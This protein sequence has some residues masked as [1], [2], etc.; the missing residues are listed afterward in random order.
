MCVRVGC[1]RMCE[2]KYTYIQG[3]RGKSIRMH[4]FMNYFAKPGNLFIKAKHGVT[5][6]F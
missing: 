5:N 3:S 1:V 6:Y 2:F 4:T